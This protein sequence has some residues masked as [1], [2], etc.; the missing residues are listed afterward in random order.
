MNA[1][2]HRSEMTTRFVIWDQ[3]TGTVGQPTAA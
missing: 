2:A 1:P 3:I